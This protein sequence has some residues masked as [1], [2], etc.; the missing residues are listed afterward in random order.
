MV[1]A[2]WHTPQAAATPFCDQQQHH[3]DSTEG[4]KDKPASQRTSHSTNP[5]GLML[6]LSYTPTRPTTPNRVT[7]APF[8]RPSFRPEHRLT[9]SSATSTP[10][11]SPYAHLNRTQR[12][13][14]LINHQHGQARCGSMYPHG[15]RQASP[16]RPKSCARTAI[17]KTFGS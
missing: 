17:T 2:V 3:D 4:V 5:P 6:Y 15:E 9:H 12:L 14:D 1:A 13:P 11:H 7:P 16:G 10:Q 8:H